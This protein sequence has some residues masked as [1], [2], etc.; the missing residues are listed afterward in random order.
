MA[1]DMVS[2]S[3]VNIGLGNSLS[4]SRCQAI[5]WT[6]VDLLLIRNFGIYFNEISIKIR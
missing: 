2:K 1:S 5:T 4:L 6:N 3:L